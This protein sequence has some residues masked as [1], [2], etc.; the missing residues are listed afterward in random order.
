[1]NTK[2]IFDKMTI[3]DKESK[4]IQELKNNLDK[5]YQE[6]INNCSHD[7]VF[8]YTDD[9]PRKMKFDGTYLCPACGKTIKCI[10][11]D[12][13]KKTSFKDSRVVP[14]INLS[15]ICSKE[16]YKTIREEVQD[17]MDLYYDYIIPTEELSSKMENKLIEKENNYESPVLILKRNTKK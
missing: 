13:L 4:R 16:I 15:L 12:Q 3:L 8:K 1:M 7:I 5:K 17:N 11:K 6:L 9:Y 14:L 10:N 2:D